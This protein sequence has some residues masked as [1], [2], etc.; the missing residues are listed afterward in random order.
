MV[1]EPL[2]DVV[3]SIFRGEIPAYSSGEIPSGSGE[4]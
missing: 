2:F 1:R 4:T 3:V